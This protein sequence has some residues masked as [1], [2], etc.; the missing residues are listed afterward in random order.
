M[1]HAVTMLDDQERLIEVSDS[2]A[3]LV[4]HVLSHSDLSVVV[5]ELLLNW[6]GAKVHIAHDVSTL[7]APVSDDA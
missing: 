7:V 5:D 1:N 3:K 6:I 4:V 2:Q